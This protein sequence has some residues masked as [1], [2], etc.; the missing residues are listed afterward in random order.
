MAGYPKLPKGK[1]IYGPFRDDDRAGGFILGADDKLVG[2]LGSFKPADQDFILRAM[3]L[4]GSEDGRDLL[5]RLM[6][7]EAWAEYDAGN[8]VC[9]NGAGWKVMASL[10]AA[11]RIIFYI[12]TGDVEKA[13]AWPPAP[14]ER[15][16][17]DA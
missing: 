14:T 6:E 17:K 4:L 15:K 5:A 13:S 8:G 10:E 7:P 1:H 11:N 16:R 2:R 9:S 12:R 3:N